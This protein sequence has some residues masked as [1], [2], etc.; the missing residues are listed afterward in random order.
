MYESLVRPTKAVSKGEFPLMKLSSTHM[1]PNR[2]PA[3]VLNKPVPK[4]AT[5]PPKPVPVE[6]EKPPAQIE[7]K[8][9]EFSK[10][11]LANSNLHIHRTRHDPVNIYWS[12]PGF[13]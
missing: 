6:K 1:H 5:F 8:M 11:L 4:V 2:P 13:Q 12:M 9:D 3:E 7:H 10:G